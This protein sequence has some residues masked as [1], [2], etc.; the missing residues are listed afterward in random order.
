MR[1][2]HLIYRV[3]SRYSTQNLSLL[4][5]QEPTGVGSP[6]KEDQE[7]ML[8]CPTSPRSSPGY[9]YTEQDLLLQRRRLRREREIYSS[10]RAYRPPRLVR[11]NAFRKDR[12]GVIGDVPECLG[13][14][15]SGGGEA[16]N[17]VKAGQGQEGID[18]LLPELCLEGVAK[19]SPG[20]SR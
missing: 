11:S 13:E 19:G 17:K 2:E 8:R 18:S 12:F 1:T 10:R 3:T 6:K 14:I 20:E 16:E 4:L 9:G 5:V 7:P 15:L